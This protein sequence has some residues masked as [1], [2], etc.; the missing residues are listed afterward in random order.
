MKELDLSHNGWDGVMFLHE[1]CFFHVFHTPT[2]T[3]WF[4]PGL[5]LLLSTEEQ[6]NV[7]I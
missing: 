5:S 2:A 1:E 6:F 3:S 4:L 7:F